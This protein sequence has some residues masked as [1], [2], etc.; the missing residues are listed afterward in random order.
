[1]KREAGT[2]TMPGS[3]DEP[4]LLVSSSLRGGGRLLGFRLVQFAS[5]FLLSLVAARALGPEGRGQ[6]ALALNLATLVWVVTHFSV[7]QS[8]SRMLARREAT[9]VELCR[10]SSLFVL[11]LGLLGTAVALAIGILARGGMLGDATVATV[12]LAAAT[13]PFTLAGQMATALLLRTGELRAYGWIIALASIV[14]LGLVVA[15]E[16]GVGLTPALAMVA[17]LATIALMAIAL[18]AVLARRIGL[19][20]LIPGA[21]M[22][23]V[24]SA[25][26]VGLRLQPASVALWL[27][28]K[29]DL[30]LVGL[31]TSAHQAG[32]YSLSANLADIVFTAVSTIGLAALET[33][34]RADAKAAAAYTADFISQ[35]LAIAAALGLIAAAVAYPFIV[36]V[37][38]SEWQ[39]SVLPFVV[40]MPAVVALAVEGPARDLLIRLAPPALISA[41]S[42]AGLG[43]NVVL[44]FILIPTIGI[45]GA[46]LASVLSY[47]LAGGLMLYML[48]RYGEVPVRRSL[49]LLHREDALPSLLRSRLGRAGS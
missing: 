8:V 25:L 20:A 3:I 17:A 27:N 7:E 4:D 39:A 40:L 10:L 15:L 47:W 43:L 37:Y 9:I 13:I 6:Y 26:R 31:L 1:M 33:Q 5:L 36:F 42:A 21:T 34:T 12:A 24:R 35:N 49:R 41:A 32:I 30:L 16:V 45:V 23:L 38:G 44:N 48:S 19:R 28:L 2:E 18:A 14:Q 29:I 46:S 11:T 22:A